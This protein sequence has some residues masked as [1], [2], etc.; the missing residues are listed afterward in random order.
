MKNFLNKNLGWLILTIMIT[1]AIVSLISDVFWLKK[2][3]LAPFVVLAGYSSFIGFSSIC[4][5]FVEDT[6]SQL[7]GGLLLLTYAISMIAFA[8]WLTEW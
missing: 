1:G 4:D 8:V 3:L 6:D 5:K 7:K 2:F